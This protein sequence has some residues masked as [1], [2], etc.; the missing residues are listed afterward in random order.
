MKFQYLQAIDLADSDVLISGRWNGGRGLK[1]G[2][3]ESSPWQ[4]ERLE[5][6]LY[7]WL[8]FPLADKSVSFL[9]ED[10]T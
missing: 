1:P 6:G 5:V 4:Q 10:T 9:V 3:E 8:G 2:S 7:M